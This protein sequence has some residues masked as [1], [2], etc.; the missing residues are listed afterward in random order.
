MRARFTTSIASAD[1]DFSDG[2]EVSVEGT[3]F[4]LGRIPERIG[5]SWI[6]SGVLVP[7]ELEAAALRAPETAARP[8]AQARRAHPRT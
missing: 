6:A 7:I 1:F 5:R 8:Q 2:T 4:G 3:Q